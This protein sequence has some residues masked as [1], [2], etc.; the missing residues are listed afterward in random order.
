MGRAE[1]LIGRVLVVED[2]PGVQKFLSRLI[3]TTGADVEAA[4]TGE[5]ALRALPLADDVFMAILDL[6]LPDASGLDI[7]RG[8]RK[9]H[10]RLPVILSSGYDESEIPR[11]WMEDPYLRFLRKPYQIAT[12]WEAFDSVLSV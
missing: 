5:E 9:T 4:C 8:I 3:G 2:E 10:S 12:F 11:E 1:Q 6:N 7:L